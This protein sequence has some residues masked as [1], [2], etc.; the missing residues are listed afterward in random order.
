[1]D[2]DDLEAPIAGLL[3]EYG[4][5]LTGPVE[6][7]L[8]SV[9]NENYR[10]PTTV[11]PLFV[12]RHQERRTFDRLER[13][14]QAIAWAGANGLPVARPLST[15]AG[16]TL[17]E[18]GGRWWSAYPWLEGWTYQRGSI[19]PPIWRSCRPRPVCTRS[20]ISATGSTP[21]R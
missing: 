7:V 4:A 14:H 5:V 10:A 13:E 3:R 2:R 19:S 18:A 8:D 12:R 16:A 15:A 20:P 9:S 17:R 1:M 6:H 11:G 21:P